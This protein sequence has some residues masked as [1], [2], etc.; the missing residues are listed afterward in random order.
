[1]T[2]CSNEIKENLKE[3]F[4]EYYDSS[5]ELAK[6]NEEGR[7]FTDHNVAHSEMVFD[8]SSEVIRAIQQYESKQQHGIDDEI[9]PFSK[10]INM[11]IIKA[12]AYAHDTGMCGLGYA[13]V[14]NSEGDYIENEEGYY[15]VKSIDSNNYSEIRINHG[16]NSAINLLM[17]RNDL[18]KLGFSDVD[19]EE[20]A[21]VCMA[22][23]I[24]T[25][26]LRNVNNMADWNECFKRLESAVIAYN[27]EH[28]NSPISFERK[29]LENAN[30]F[31]NLATEVF[32][33]RLGDVSR[34]AGQDDVSQSG[35]KVYI[36]RRTFNN[37]GGS[38]GLE[39]QNA[40][41]TIG[42]DNTPITFQKSRQVHAG[43]PNIIYNRTFTNQD[44]YFIH[45]ITVEDGN[46]VPKCTQQVIH[47]HL[48][49]INTAPDFKFIVRIIFKSNCSNFA[50][51]S[52][53]EFREECSC[54][55]KNVVITFP[56][57]KINK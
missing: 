45:E 24:S 5:C 25:S 17:K 54:E 27:L 32:A 13:L 41:I 21:V 29:L 52:Y 1:M 7:V 57:D 15:Q 9:I 40:I 14:K 2:I 38:I 6:V 46:F 39:I 53:E 33:V 31:S 55:F 3:I 56:W 22:H 11:N 18:K 19:I 10:N 8:K 37:E 50:Q 34:D 23:F 43:E 49:V 16:L 44:N 12:V 36:E 4:K 47:D 48:R 51:K 30:R 26:G 42:M 20:I 28:S 35:E